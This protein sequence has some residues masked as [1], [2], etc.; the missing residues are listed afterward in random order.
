MSK[1]N[2]IRR[3]RRRKPIRKTRRTPAMESKVNPA[4][5]PYGAFGRSEPVDAM[6]DAPV[7]YAELM[8]SEYLR[9]HTEQV[10]DQLSAKFQKE[11]DAEGYVALQ[12]QIQA[13][14]DHWKLTAAEAARLVRV[15]EAAWRSGEWRNRCDAELVFRFTMVRS[16]VETVENEFGY[17][18]TMRWLR[19]PESQ[20]RFN[21]AV[22]LRELTSH[23]SVRVMTFTTTVG[24]SLGL[25]PP[26]DGFGSEQSFATDNEGQQPSRP[27]EW[28]PPTDEDDPEATSDQMVGWIKDDL[29]ATLAAEVATIT[30]PEDSKQKIAEYARLRERGIEPPEELLAHVQEAGIYPSFAVDSEMRDNISKGVV[31]MQANLDEPTH[32]ETLKLVMR[33]M[34]EFAEHYQLSNTEAAQLFDVEEA[35]WSSGEW[36]SLLNPERALRWIAVNGILNWMYRAL[37]ASLSVRWLREPDRHAVFGGVVPMAELSQRDLARLHMYAAF[38][39]RIYELDEDERM[40]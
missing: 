20:P 23:D 30:D 27:D 32:V 14:V 19:E 11:I 7:Q 1:A 9:R 35:A 15:D 21:G 2:R 25:G 17:S 28:L 40:G 3:A 33:E 31:Y 36:T 29:Q 16:T 39:M 26:L 22:P 4:D 38:V 10:I 34:K 37:G 24:L 12:Q 8:G 18:K 6:L 5:F 13:F